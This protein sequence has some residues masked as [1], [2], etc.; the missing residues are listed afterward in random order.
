MFHLSHLSRALNHGQIHAQG[1]CSNFV[2]SI[3]YCV[4]STFAHILF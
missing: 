1:Y 2:L 4:L 3:Q